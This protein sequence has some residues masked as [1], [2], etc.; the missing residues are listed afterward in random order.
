MKHGYLDIFFAMLLAVGSIAFFGFH[1]NLNSI[2]IVLSVLLVFILPGYT[3]SV[4]LFP[5]PLLSIIER[6]VLT[7]GLSLVL[8]IFSGFLLYSLSFPLQVETWAFSLGMEVIVFGIVAVFRRS[9]LPKFKLKRESDIRNLAS[10]V[11]L[12]T[13]GQFFL[14]GLSAMLVLGSFILAQNIAASEPNTEVV[15]LWILPGKTGEGVREI[16]IGAMINDNAPREY[17][18]WLGRDDF[19]IKEWPLLVLKPGERWENVITIDNNLPGKGPLDVYLYSYEQPDIPYRHV[20]LWLDQ[21]Q[22]K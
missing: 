21:S 12:P 15:Q 22:H 17:Y 4:V 8:T 9:Q 3:I 1:L 11:S 20:T 2:Q 10:K 14:F 19:T 16:Q 7:I 18:L 13:I 5:S 6:V